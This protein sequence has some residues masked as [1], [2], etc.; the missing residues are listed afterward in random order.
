MAELLSDLAPPLEAERARA[1]ARAAERR[2]IL[3]LIYAAVESN[4]SRAYHNF[5]VADP[6]VF[7]MWR[8]AYM[9]ILTERHAR[10]IKAGEFAFVIARQETDEWRAGEFIMTSREYADHLVLMEYARPATEAEKL[11]EIDDRQRPEK[12]DRAVSGIGR[13]FAFFELRTQ[14]RGHI[15]MAVAQWPN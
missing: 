1:A 11:R 13:S 15:G 3:E 10:Q 9:E 6:D 4:H 2:L 8:Q 12:I 5:V 14:Q 7:E